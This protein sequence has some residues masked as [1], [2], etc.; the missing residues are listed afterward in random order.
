MPKLNQAQLI[1]NYLYEEIAIN[2]N[3]RHADNIKGPGNIW[4]LAMN[5]C[6]CLPF[7]NSKM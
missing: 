6:R 4:L 1:R 2:N 3:N 7:G 5:P